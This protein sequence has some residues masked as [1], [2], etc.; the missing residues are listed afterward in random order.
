MKSWKNR[1]FFATK[2]WHFLKKFEFSN[3][4]YSILESFLSHEIIKNFKFLKLADD[5]LLRF[6]ERVWLPY[7]TY[8]FAKPNWSPSVRYPS[9]WDSSSWENNDNADH[10]FYFRTISERWNH[11][12]NRKMFAKKT[13]F[14][15]K[16]WIFKLVL[17]YFRIKRDEIMKKINK[18]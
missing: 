12:K 6:W 4:F 7:C 16:V 5:A 18:F 11:G 1:K 17:L 9:E 8:R 10:L 2:K 14:L 3:L 13:F 15:E